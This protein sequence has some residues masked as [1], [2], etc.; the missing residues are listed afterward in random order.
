MLLAIPFISNY[1]FWTQL[2]ILTSLF[3]LSYTHRTPRLVIATVT[4]AYLAWQ[5]VVPLVRWF[6]IA[7]KAVAW[8]GF[9][10]HFFWIAVTMA[11]NAVFWVLEEAL[12]RML[13][14]MEAAAQN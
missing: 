7:F 2:W 1:S 13:R 3:I 8:F 6:T 11:C 9:Y 10:L 12:P 14:E 4:S 5:I